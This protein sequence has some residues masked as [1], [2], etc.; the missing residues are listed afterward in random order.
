MRALAGGVEAEAESVGERGR[1]GSSQVEGVAPCLVGP[2]RARRRLEAQEVYRSGLFLS[3]RLQIPT[4]ALFTLI[5][6]ESV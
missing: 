4:F 6:R 5:T 1:R 3:A 2:T